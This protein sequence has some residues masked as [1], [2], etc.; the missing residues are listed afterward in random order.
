MKSLSSFKTSATFKSYMNESATPTAQ[1]KK[2]VAI[3]PS[4]IPNSKDKSF[5]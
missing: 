1:L 5:F 3:P 2:L 4:G